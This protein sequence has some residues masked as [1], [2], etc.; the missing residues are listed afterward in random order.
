MEFSAYISC[1]LAARTHAVEGGVHVLRDLEDVPL[2]YERVLGRHVDRELG[3]P[4]PDGRHPVSGPDLTL[5]H[6]VILEQHRGYPQCP[7]LCKSQN[8]QVH[9]VGKLDQYFLIFAAPCLYGII[10]IRGASATMAM[11]RGAG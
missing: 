4:R 8:S 11:A 10:R 5:E 9:L 3:A 7:I 6:G 2:L 1:G